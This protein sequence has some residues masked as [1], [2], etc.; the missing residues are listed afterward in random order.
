MAHDPGEQ[1]NKVGRTLTLIGI[2]VLPIL[3][4]LNCA[5]GYEVRCLFNIFP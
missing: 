5:Q 3:V 4:P 2:V 1:A